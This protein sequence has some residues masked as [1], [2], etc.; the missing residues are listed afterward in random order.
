MSK[1]EYTLGVSGDLTVG[2]G[3][4]YIFNHPKH[5]STFSLGK[6]TQVFFSCP[7]RKPNVFWRLMQ[8]LFFGFVW[9]DYE[10]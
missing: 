9:K 6:E 2:T 7:V 10:E 1:S 5:L 4:T 3:D 8:H